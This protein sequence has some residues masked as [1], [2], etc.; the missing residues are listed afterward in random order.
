MNINVIIVGVLSMLTAG[1]AHAQSSI[2]MFGHLDAGLQYMTTPKGNTLTA[3]SGDFSESFW[4]LQGTEDLGGGNKA[5]FKLISGFDIQN[6]QTLQSGLFGYYATVGLVNEAYGAIR[7]GRMGT[8]EISQLV[9]YADP[10]QEQFFGAST[11]VRGRNFT[12]ASNGI[13]YTSP[14]W[15]GLFLQGQY[16]LTNSTK[17]NSG[18]PGSGPGQVENPQGRADGLRVQYDGQRFSLTAIYDEIRDPQGQFSNV[19]LASRSAL[20]GG[21]AAVGPVK[22]YAGFQHLSAPG[23]SNQ[24]YFGTT[25]AANLPSA[26]SL[27]T[28]ADQE[29]LGAAWQITPFATLIGAVYH[30]NANNGNGNATL[31]TLS[32]QYNLSKR[33]Y[34]YAELGYIHNSSTSNIGL[35]DGFTD[36]YGPNSNNDPALSNNTRTSPNYG[37][38]QFGA[39]A[40]IVTA[41]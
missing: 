28:V 19:Y 41:F 38:G 37:H 32:G 25:T 39:T 20:I 40:G 24:G 21:V 13:E 8:N 36:P 11:L 12:K 35:S 29:W 23:A 14:T 33:T 18:N 15:G 17:W 22:L 34:L 4:G 7:L 1:V 3:A 2:N 10:Q 6:G 31:Y 5:V 16:D 26:V 30:A 9:Y 27:P